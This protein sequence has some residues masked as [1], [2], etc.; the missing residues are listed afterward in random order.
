MMTTARDTTDNRNMNDME[1]WY[2][3]RITAMKTRISELETALRNIIE[4]GKRDMRNP[5]YDTYFT[6]AEDL[7]KK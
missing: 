4:I 6:A 5:K 3:S 1:E 2:T 7:L